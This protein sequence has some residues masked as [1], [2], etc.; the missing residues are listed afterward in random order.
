MCIKNKG[1]E[2]MSGLRE[3]Y[4]MGIRGRKNPAADNVQFLLTKSENSR[5]LLDL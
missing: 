5:N 1:F 2:M 4:G 3:T